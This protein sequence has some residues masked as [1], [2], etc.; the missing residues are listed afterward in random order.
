MNEDISKLIAL[1]EVDFE[2]AGFDRQVHEK[3]QL[4]ANRIQAIEDKEVKISQCAARSEELQ[5]KQTDI[6]TE[7]E[8]AQA[9]IK[10][11]QN[12]MMLVQTSREHQALLKEIEDNKKLIKDCEEKLLEVMQQIEN[13][14]KE[15]EELKNLC[16]GE[17]EILDEETDRI[18]QEIEDVNNRKAT[19]KE[20]RITLSGDLKGN[21]LKRYDLLLT[22]KSGA[23]VVKTVDGV[24]Q[25]CYMTIPPQQFNQV[26]KG[27]SMNFCP[28]C[29]RILYYKAEEAEAVEG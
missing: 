9:L 5:Q 23:A 27:D 4:I 25:G 8:E 11:R 7:L 6:K 20:K 16:K 28:S 2:I 14:D 10:E 13:L 1:Q 29:Q 18:K 15:A 22:R 17:K 21:I 12:K 26:R 3:E 24:C 19:I